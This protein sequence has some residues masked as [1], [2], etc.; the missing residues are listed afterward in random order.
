MYAVL[1]QISH[2]LLIQ[3]VTCITNQPSS[4]NWDMWISPDI[5]QGQQIKLIYLEARNLEI[6]N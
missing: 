3:N 6:V 1:L 5:C 4:R 2:F